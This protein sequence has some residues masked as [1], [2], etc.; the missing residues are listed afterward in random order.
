MFSACHGQI[1]FQHVMQSYFVQ[2][3]MGKRF[4]HVMETCVQHVME[5]TNMRT[6]VQEEFESTVGTAHIFHYES[7]DFADS[8]LLSIKGPHKGK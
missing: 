1:C 5:K 6:H 7:L 8:H 3:V 2:H 4:Q